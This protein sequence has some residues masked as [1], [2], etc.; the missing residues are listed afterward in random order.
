MAESRREYGVVVG[1]ETVMCR[2]KDS[3]KLDH[4]EIR[5]EGAV[6][7]NLAQDRNRSLGFCQH[8]NGLQTL[9]APPNAL[10]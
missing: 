2:R 7:I 8:G 3:S 1:T 5:R 9:S 10:F 4:K 6:S